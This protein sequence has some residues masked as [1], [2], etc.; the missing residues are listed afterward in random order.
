LFSFTN[1]IIAA[2]IEKPIAIPSVTKL[3]NPSTR[4]IIIAITA[5]KNDETAKDVAKSVFPDSLF[6]LKKDPKKVIMNRE[7]NNIGVKIGTTWAGY[8]NRLAIPV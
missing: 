6:W 2:T 1:K 5:T 7:N 8:V 4:V 3:I